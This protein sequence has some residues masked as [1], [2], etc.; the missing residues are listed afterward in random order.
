MSLTKIT[1][2]TLKRKKVR[3]TLA[4]IGLTVCVGIV[5][6]V[7]IST[8][9]LY[10]SY[11]NFIMA[12]LGAPDIYIMK[13]GFRGIDYSLLKNISSL[14]WVETV[15][16]RLQLYGVAFTENS[17]NYRTC[18]IVGVNARS[19]LKLKKPKML[20]GSFRMDEYHCVISSFL[21]YTLNVSVGENV[22]FATYIPTL[23]LHLTLNLTVSG[24]LDPVQMGYPTYSIVVDLLKLQLAIRRIVV[25]VV[26]IKVDNIENVHTY[27]DVLYSMLGPDYLIKSPKADALKNLNQVFLSVRTLLTFVSMFSVVVGVLLLTNVL[28]IGLEE[29][30][31]EIGILR[32]IGASRLQIFYM[33]LLEAFIIGILG[34]ILG[35]LSGVPLSK[36]VLNVILSHK[37]LAHLARIRLLFTVSKTTLI[38]TISTGVAAT[39]VSAI[40]PA[41]SA[42]KVNV[43]EA[44][45]P[46]MKSLPK[47]R[48][49]KVT[50]LTGLLFVV[51]SAYAL[52]YSLPE[53][54]PTFYAIA[55]RVLSALTFYVGIVLIFAGAA[56]FVIKAFSYMLY[57]IIKSNRKIVA[58]ELIRQRRRSSL[59]F[60]MIS[61]GLALMMFT[62]ALSSTIVESARRMCPIAVGSDIRIYV[63]DARGNPPPSYIQY[64]LEKNVEGVLYVSPIKRKLLETPFGESVT[65][66]GVDPTRYWRIVE[67]EIVEG[68]SVE[69]VFENLRRELYTAII[70]S[71]LAKNMSAHVG[72]SITLKC[73]AQNITFKVIAI[74]DSFIGFPEIF[75][76][77]L[78]AMYISMDTY[79][80]IFGDKEAHDFAIKVVSGYSQTEVEE[81]I[82]SYLSS[83]GFIVETV[84]QEKAFK[85]IKSYID[86]MASIAS[87]FISFSIIAAML[88]IFITMIS[89]YIER[90]FELAILMTV[91][92]DK[93]Q[94][95]KML[96]CEALLLSLIGL[97]IGTIAG[98]LSWWLLLQRIYAINPMLKYLLPYIFPTETFVVCSLIAVAVSL[99]ASL[100]PL[101]KITKMN[102]VEALRYIG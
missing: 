30:K 55:F 89:S 57:P 98:N 34:T 4:V 56:N 67:I 29:R 100:Y 45:R 79:K 20:N 87:F 6:A 86:E 41:Y 78:C 43:V 70:S 33:V 38:I 64:E 46:R 82:S 101:F 28:L 66:I 48:I 65:V 35:L 61:V 80:A 81:K 17:S 12:R 71:S 2:R 3:F 5:A 84:S 96:L 25:N 37:L 97:A 83:K 8:D 52:L 74:T 15:A 13:E 102:V 24:I 94:L 69:D 18:H 32:S 22:T 85:A 92:A 62:A 72:G 63:S 95:A 16:G 40:Y 21:S 75:F 7:N 39:I 54:I 10:T 68:P 59:S 36:L 50:T 99:L 44:L 49:M 53:G 76:G 93:K 58:R 47:S 51:F 60:S 73:G 88:G 9:T 27:V 91:G 23:K 11:M 1:F 77:R 42:S 14:E 26:A 31:I 90:R 19:E